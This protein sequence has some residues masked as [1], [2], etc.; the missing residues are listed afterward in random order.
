MALPLVNV[1]GNHG[2]VLSPLHFG[3]IFRSQIDEGV[4]EV[5]KTL[6]GDL[7]GQFVV[8]GSFYGNLG[9]FRPKDLYAHQ[10]SLERHNSLKKKNTKNSN[11][12]PVRKK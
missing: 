7:H 10:S 3:Q 4:E 1:Y 6:I 8:S 2:F 11:H 12:I 9:L 5:E